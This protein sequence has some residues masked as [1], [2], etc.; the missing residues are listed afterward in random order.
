VK[1]ERCPPT[2]FFRAIIFREAAGDREFIRLRTVEISP[3]VAEVWD[4]R[5]FY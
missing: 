2:L 5:E 4:D 3:V 1:R